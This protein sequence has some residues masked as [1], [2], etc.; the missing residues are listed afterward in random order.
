MTL[1]CKGI[2]RIKY[3]KKHQN[4]IKLSSLR[5]K[6]NICE[7]TCPTLSSLCFNLDHKIKFIFFLQY[8]E[9]NK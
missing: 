5:M 9:A 3:T 1:K 8:F 6:E 7:V 2:L 4:Q